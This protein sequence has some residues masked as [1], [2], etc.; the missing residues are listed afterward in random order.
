[1]A[2]GDSI[3]K[4]FQ[5]NTVAKG[6]AK[7]LL[8]KSAERVLGLTP[9]PT[10]AE[11]IE[12]QVKTSGATKEDFFVAQ[13]TVLSDPEELKREIKAIVLRDIQSGVL[14]S[15]TIKNDVNTY[16]KQKI[17]TEVLSKISPAKKTT[18]QN[19][20][21]DAGAMLDGLGAL[22]GL[23][24]KAVLNPI[25][26]ISLAGT[27]SQKLLTS[28]QYR[29]EWYNTWVKPTVEEYK[30]YRDPKTKWHED[31]LDVLLDMTIVAS[32]VGGGLK[33]A[34]ATTL[35]GVAKSTEVA[36][37]VR[38]AQEALKLA[39]TAE[40]TNAATK[41]LALAR[42]AAA[43]VVPDSTLFRAGETAVS[44][45]EK[46]AHPLSF[47]NIS[48]ATKTIVRAVP[49]G[50][51]L[52][53]YLELASDT[54]KVVQKETL[55]HLRLLERVTNDIDTIVKRLTPDEVKLLPQAAQGFVPIPAGA[56]EGFNQALG[57]LRSLSK[58]SERLGLKQGVFTHEILERRNFQPL[59][60]WLERERKLET[61]RVQ[62]TR[63]ATEQVVAKR[64]TDI[65]K[66]R[67]EMSS[68]K[69]AT[70]DGKQ[71]LKK[72]YS[73]I[74]E[75]KKNLEGVRDEFGYTS[76]TG[77]ELRVYIKKIQDFF[78]DADPIYMRHFF[79][80]APRKF[81]AFVLNTR[82]VRTWKPGSVKKSYG[83]SGYIGE[84]GNV[85]K[86]QLK[87]VLTRQAAETIKW[88]KNIDLIEKLKTDPRVRRLRV[89]EAPRD[90]YTI[91]APDGLLRFYKTTIDVSE[92]LS[93]RVSRI[94]KDD[95]VWSVV[96]NAFEDVFPKIEK[97]YLAAT[98]ATLYEMPIAM[99]KQVQKMAPSTMPYVKLFWDKPLDAFRYSVLAFFPRWQ[100]NNVM[101]NVIFST[102]KGDI[103]NPKAWFAYSNAKKLGLFPDEL[104]A[105]VHRAE[106]TTAGHLGAAADLPIV[107]STAALHNA[108]L[109]TRV[110]GKIVSNIERGVT[111]GVFAPMKVVGDFSF[112][113]NA[114]VDDFFK[115]IGYIN[116]ALRT[117]RK[118]FI[119]RMLTSQKETMAILEKTAQSSKLTAK[120]VDG[121]HNWY[122]HGLNL[123]EFERR[124]VR[125]LVPFYSWMRWITLYS[126][127]VT[128]EAPVRTAIIRGFA[129]DFYMLTGQ[130]K[131]P[132]YL[133]G[134]VPIQ[135]DEDGSVYYLKTQGMNPF[136][137]LNNLMG[138][139]LLGTALQSSAPGIKTLAD[140]ATGRDTFTG[141]QFTRNDVLQAMSGRLYKFDPELG[142]VVEVDATV[143]PGLL[144][145]LLR[146][147]IPQYVLMETLLTAGEKRYTA[148]GLN[149]ILADLFVDESERK[150][151]VLD[152]IT[153]QG[154]RDEKKEDVL[155]TELMK[156]IGLNIKE[157]EPEAQR[158]TQKSLEAATT[159]ILNREMP[160]LN[161][162]FKSMIRERV[163]Q[164]VAKGTPKEDIK[165]MI[166][167][168]IALSAVGLQSSTVAE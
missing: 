21:E 147:Y 36:K 41:A 31:P 16:I 115:G 96:A 38:T 50:D 87:D 63:Q 117:E 138:E 131:L 97:S 151:I 61:P 72:L 78:P 53:R 160:I 11:V 4:F 165:Q 150:A 62:T 32:F 103:F 128:T 47:K 108:M 49:G 89:G 54:R 82:P 90:G 64:N 81:S 23:S 123:T 155:K 27:T 80:D 114:M 44:V 35:T 48:N 126:Y 142:E 152:I 39:R 139:G 140:Q 144:E 70:A 158:A 13:E 113:L 40:E 85:T 24:V 135:T 116:D 148:E 122:Y 83:R 106:R 56:S 109:D 20:Q 19:F 6:V 149:T 84:G 120:L 69:L 14:K 104:F 43:G 162:R 79:E 105:G 168:W 76:L 167:T 141:Q 127:R 34:G 145:N 8:P 33:I 100:F 28:P 110:V 88:K 10:Q 2:F 86:E 166:K 37:N 153:Q 3:L 124:I 65:A 91:F 26:T 99:A 55:T 59:A 133:R 58:E 95:N 25:D 15:S 7:F 71:Q 73:Q 101:G 60:K 157:V 102:I 98:K 125:R 9:P 132:E 42:K 57:M 161:E 121:V 5:T 52:V 77:D 74:D 29:Q 46:I 137:T 107:K 66:I 143:R 111:K 119:G 94:A 30:E 134:A 75:A 118:G 17:N 136:D 45:G 1:M 22:V 146:N 130:N 92:E 112:K 129:R 156:A 51:D 18:W 93:R 164:E 12:K 154:T 68:G 159:A 67:A 163:A